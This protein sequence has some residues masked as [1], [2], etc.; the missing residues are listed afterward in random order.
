MRKC[1]PRAEADF[2]EQAEQV[3]E[4]ISSAELSKCLTG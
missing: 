3:G 2:E 4:L 1:S